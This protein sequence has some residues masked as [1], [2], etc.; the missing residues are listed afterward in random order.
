MSEQAPLL[1]SEPASRLAAGTADGS[2]HPVVV[3]RIKGGLRIQLHPASA[4]D[5]H[6]RLVLTGPLTSS[7]AALAREALQAVAAGSGPWLLVDVDGVSCLDRSGLAV[8]VAALHHVRRLAADGCLHLIG[9]SGSPSAR[10]LAS[11]GLW[12][13]LPLHQDDAVPCAAEPLEL[14]TGGRAGPNALPRP[15]SPRP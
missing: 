3:A 12:K 9:D 15:V 10:A 2:D 1:P 13:A 6:S 4:V 8:L 14:W 5:R 11:S 7:S